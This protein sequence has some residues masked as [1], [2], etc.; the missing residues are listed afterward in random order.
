MRSNNIQFNV[1][2]INHQM[3]ELRIYNLVKSINFIDTADSDWVFFLMYSMQY[4][5]FYQT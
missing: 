2:E 5:S 4:T 3:L 1:L